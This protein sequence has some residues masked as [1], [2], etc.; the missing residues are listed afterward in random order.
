MT[1][2]ATLAARAHVDVAYLLVLQGLPFMV[3]TRAEIAGSGGGSWIGT[4]YGPRRVIEGL[5]ITGASLT[6]ATETGDGRPDTD[7][8]LTVKIVDFERD[9]IELFRVQTVESGDAIPVGGR[10]GPKDD[11]APTDLIGTS[12]D[13]VPIWGQWVNAE[14]IGPAGERSYYSL[15]PGGDPAGQDHA[16]YSGDLQSL[17]PSYVY[18]SPTHLE[19]RRAALYRIFRDLDTGEWP[20]WGDHHDSGVSLIWVGSMTNDAEVNDITWSLKFEGPS[21]WLRKQLGA[22]RSAEW[23]PVSGDITLSDA[24]GAREDLIA[25]NFRYQQMSD[26]T[27]ELGGVSIFD[28]GLDTLP[29]TGNAASFRAAINARIATVS[30]S[31]GADI[32]WTTDRNAEAYLASGYAETRIDDTPGGGFIKA[33]LWSLAAHEKAWRA[34]GYDPY[35]Q[36]ATGYDTDYEIRFVAGADSGLPV[37]GP[38][39]WVGHFWTVPVGYASLAAAGADAD[40]NGQVRRARA[41]A[42]EDI[43]QLPPGAGFELSFG[44]GSPAYFEGQTNRATAEHALSNA[45]GD[46]DTQGYV[47][48]RGSYLAGPDAEVQTMVQ[49][50]QVCWHADAVTLGGDTIGLDS[51]GHARVYVAKWID[52]RFHGIDRKPLNRIWASADL[53]WCPVNFMGHA[54]GSGDYAHRMMLRLLLSTG[55]ATWTGYDGDGAVLTPGANHP[56]ALDGLEPYSDAEIADLGLGI[57]HALIDLSSFG[58]AAGSLPGGIT[59]PLNR[60]RYAWIG[61]EDSQEMIASML[62][63]RGWGLGFNRGKWRL[64]SRPDLLTAEDVAVTIEPDDIEGEP[65]FVETASLRPFTP[66]ERFKVTFDH[67]LVSDAATDDRELFAEVRALDPSSRS[68]RDNGVADIEGRGLIPIP[69]WRGD[70]PPADWRSAWQ[71]LFA[72]IMAGWFNSA[73]TMISGLPVLPSIAR[74]VGPGTVVRFTSYYAPTREGTYGPAAKLGRIYKVEHDLESCGAKIDVLL[75]PG[76]GL[77]VRFFAPVARVLDDVATVEERHD[78]ASRTFFCYRDA[79]GHGAE[80]M[81]DVRLFA[82]PAWLGVGGDA[83]VHGWQWNGREWSQAFSFTVES[84]STAANSITYKD[85]TLTGAWSESCYTAILLAPYDDQPLASWPRALFSVLT[86]HDFKFGAGPTQGFPLV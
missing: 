20:S 50:A 72:S 27:I 62:A 83:V 67:A 65:E 23:L 70:N 85:G 28:A 32:T 9:L 60:C 57:P 31:A 68:R 73:H 36:A 86:R 38:G 75:Q 26:S 76:D 12:G 66:R 11:P 77:D 78:A 71:A 43:A 29:T 45:G 46:C 55:T 24:P 81:H 4:G 18:A 34:M 8:G 54:F 58:K 79:F 19:G 21:S 41:I 74:Q 47:A 59:S 1:S 2:V 52:P 13:N 82:E 42:P 56:A 69:L 61:A 64:F 48:F 17:A 7:D 16:A 84:V 63:P 80:D 37:P 51:L 33:A 35:A 14:A 44:I 30:A 40:N 3:T 22:Q 5:D 49:L 15:F 10:L 39:Y 25:L 6:F 53:E